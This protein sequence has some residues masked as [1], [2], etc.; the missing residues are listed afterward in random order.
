MKIDSFEF[1]CDD[2]GKISPGDGQRVM[3]T[4]PETMRESAGTERAVP[5]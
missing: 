3:D 2:P 5:V 4:I 1:M